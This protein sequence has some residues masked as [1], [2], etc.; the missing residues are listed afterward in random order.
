MSLPDGAA[1]VVE[2][3]AG[4]S[5]EAATVDG[6][7]AEAPSLCAPQAATT[8]S[9]GRSA[10]PP[11]ARRPAGRRVRPRLMQLELPLPVVCGQLIICGFY[12]TRLPPSVAKAFAAGD[13][14]GAVLFARNLTPDLAQ[15]A[16]LNRSLRDAGRSELPPLVAVDQEGGRVTRLPPETLILPP[17]Q[18]LGRLGNV[19]LIRRA[20]RAQALE[21]AALGFSMNFAPVLDVNTC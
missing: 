1:S 5:V 14:G 2:G 9:A 11:R 15:I 18:A 12:G 3:E 17:M 6:A 10:R 20:A 16:D 13:R 7:L 19:D 8:R 4:E 21:L